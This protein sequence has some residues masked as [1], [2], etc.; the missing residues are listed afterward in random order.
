[1]S[2]PSTSLGAL[3]ASLLPTGGF[4][5]EAS[6]LTAIELLMAAILFFASANGERGKSPSCTSIDT[7]VALL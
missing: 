2:T 7:Y 3:I 4:A 6:L 1:M 5:K